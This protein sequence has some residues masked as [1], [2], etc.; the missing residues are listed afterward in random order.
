MIIYAE[1]KPGRKCLVVTAN[2]K[3]ASDSV[4]TGVLMPI[5]ESI[6]SIYCV[7]TTTSFLRVL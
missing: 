5:R 3:R 7:V 2:R 1:V 6:F 4:K